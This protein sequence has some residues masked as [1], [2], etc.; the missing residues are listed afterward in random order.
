MSDENVFPILLLVARPAAGKS[1][2]IHYLTGLPLE[3]REET[4]HIGELKSIDDFPFLWRWFEEDELLE[5]MGQARLYTDQEGYFKSNHLWDLLIKLVNLDFLKFSHANEF[6]KEMTVLIEFSRGKEHGGYQH[7]LPLLSDEILENLSILYVNVPW[8]ESLRKNRRRFNPDKPDSILE[9][10]LPD[11][12]LE[13]LYREC[14]FQELV[15]AP[16]GKITIR[17]FQV[18]YAILENSD[19]VTSAMGDALGKRLESTLQ[20]LWSLRSE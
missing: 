20:K 19:D 7:A 8:E 4:F 11:T 13:R 1:E 17:G 6:S 12:K 5:K 10:S 2:I 16:V 14:D 15:D 18:P 9:H 3:K